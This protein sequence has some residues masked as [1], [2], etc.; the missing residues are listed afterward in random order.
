MKCFKYILFGHQSVLVNATVKLTFQTKIKAFSMLT[1][2]NTRS[3]SLCLNR[4]VTKETR[5]IFDAN[6]SFFLQNKQLLNGIGALLY[7]SLWNRDTD[8]IPIIYFFNTYSDR[9]NTWEVGIIHE[10]QVLFHNNNPVHQ[11]PYFSW[12]LIMEIE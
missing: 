11:G 4:V 2:K 10:R 5:N 9:E 1:I 6:S 8:C 7:I 12:E 3:F